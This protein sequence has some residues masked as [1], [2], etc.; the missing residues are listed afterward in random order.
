[1]GKPTFDLCYSEETLAA[2][3]G[4]RGFHDVPGNGT[5]GLCSRRRASDARSDCDAE[6]MRGGAAC[7]ASIMSLD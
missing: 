1:M 7:G 6:L 4:G 5:V 3:T 2:C